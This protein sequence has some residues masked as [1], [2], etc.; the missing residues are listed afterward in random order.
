MIEKPETTAV[1]E[2]R[3]EEQRVETKSAEFKKELGLTD[4]VLTQ[5]LFIVGL[6]W[7]G[8]A[9]KQGQSHIV[10]WLAAIALFYIPSAV[11]ADD[12]QPDGQDGFWRARRF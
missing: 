10:L 8:V 6:P 5:I 1:T 9:A 2:F 3:E 11:V 4:L 7:V 12:P